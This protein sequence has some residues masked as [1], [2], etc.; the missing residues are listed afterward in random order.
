MGIAKR[1]NVILFEDQ[2]HINTD[3]GARSLPQISNRIY[4]VHLTVFNH[5]MA[6]ANATFLEHVIVKA[7]A[8]PAILL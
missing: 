2:W 8:L 6:T 4:A 5:H 7:V 3:K 1:Y